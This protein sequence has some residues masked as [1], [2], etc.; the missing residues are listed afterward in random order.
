MDVD[1]VIKDESLV[2][3]DLKHMENYSPFYNMPLFCSQIMFISTFETRFQI[4]IKER[5]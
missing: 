1:F 2:S 3:K 5:I 4:F